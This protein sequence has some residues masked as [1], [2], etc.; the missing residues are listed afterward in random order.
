M[1]GD[2]EWSHSFKVELILET[3]VD[4]ESLKDLKW[5]EN[6]THSDESPYFLVTKILNVEKE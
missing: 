3:D 4:Y 2:D 1:N 6:Q 5:W